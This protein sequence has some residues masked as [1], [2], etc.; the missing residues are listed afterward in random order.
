[1]RIKQLELNSVAGTIRLCRTPIFTA[2]PLF[3]Q[4]T[5]ICHE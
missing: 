1:M 5:G 3:I 2:I 4:N